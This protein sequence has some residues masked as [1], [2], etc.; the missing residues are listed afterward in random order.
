MMILPA[1]YAE[2]RH[3]ALQHADGHVRT[4]L[5]LLRKHSA[6]FGY[7]LNYVV[8]CFQYLGRFHIVFPSASPLLFPHGAV[9]TTMGGTY[10]R[11]GIS[12]PQVDQGSEIRLSRCMPGTG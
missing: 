1:E 8:L 7:F 5:H 12:V 10:R 11:K 4:I 9:R 2:K 3:Q 6:C